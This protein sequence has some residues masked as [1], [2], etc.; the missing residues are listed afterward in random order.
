MGYRH[1]ASHISKGLEIGLGIN[2]LLVTTGD[3]DD[4]LFCLRAKYQ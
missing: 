2:M 1:R 4:Y 3:I